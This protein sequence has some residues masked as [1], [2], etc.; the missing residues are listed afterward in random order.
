MKPV[1]FELGPLTVSS[2][3]VMV[4]L[5]IL[6]GLYFAQ[7]Y[8]KEKNLDSGKV[9]NLAFYLLLAGLIGGRLVYVLTYLPDFIA[10]PIDIL[11]VQQGGLSIHGAILGGA[12]ATYF[13]C[14]HHK[15]SFLRTA[16]VLAPSLLIGQAI[17]RWG[18]FL[19]GHCEGTVT[20]FFLKVKFPL[21]PGFR[22]PVQLY[23]S[24]LDFIAF[25]ILWAMRKRFK[26]DG[27]LFAVIFI[28][29]SL[30]RFALDFIRAEN[31][32]WLFG[33]SYAQIATLI[34][35]LI[36][37]LVLAWPQLKKLQS[38]RVAHNKQGA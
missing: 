11:M 13:F 36:F 37:A 38:G 18:C 16:D 23:E 24:G 5:G 22:H 35:A 2:W 1:L 17:G 34:I 27:S 8:A 7:R 30:I 31:K 32:I 25:G 14:R 9:I 4:A 28:V 21:L 3:G 26:R 6:V 15:I 29:M 20:N 12:I 19:G 10:N 33:L